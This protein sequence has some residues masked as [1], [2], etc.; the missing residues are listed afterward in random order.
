MKADGI[1]VHIELVDE[2]FGKEVFAVV[3]V[4]RLPNRSNKGYTPIGREQ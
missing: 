2:A 1:N 3:D 4:G